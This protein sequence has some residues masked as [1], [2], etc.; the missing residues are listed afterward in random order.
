MKNKTQKVAS[1][2]VFAAM[3]WL[4]GIEDNSVSTA[5]CNELIIILIFLF[6]TCLLTF[7]YVSQ[8]I[9]SKEDEHDNSTDKGKNKVGDKKSTPLRSSPNVPS[10]LLPSNNNNSPKNSPKNSPRTRHNRSN[11]YLRNS[12]KID[13]S[14]NNDSDSGPVVS[15][16]A[17][18]KRCWQGIV[19][20]LREQDLIC[21]KGL[22]NMFYYF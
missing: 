17:R 20:D 9:S 10:R 8:I 12:G 7:R 14:N 15:N 13:K 16:N 6:F 1:S 22:L 4:Y 19:D 2:D 11:S 21:N 5:V 3:Q 18:Y